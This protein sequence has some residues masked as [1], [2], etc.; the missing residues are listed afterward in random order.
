MSVPASRSRVAVYPGTFDPIT[1]GH[2]DL[3]MRAAPLFDRLVVAIAD[4]HSKGPCFTLEERLDLARQAL[5]GIKN[6]EI[7]GFS[8]LLASF[9]NEIEAGVILR[10]LRAVSDFEYEFQLA[11]MNRHLIPEAETMFLTPAEQYSFISS[12]LV[13]EIARLG[14]DV[15]G[16]VHPVVQQALAQRWS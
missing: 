1:N 16:F 5:N 3:V 13:R 12:S 15:S 14:G 9:V 2:I 8:T 6:V 10:G 7:R 4:S 11:S